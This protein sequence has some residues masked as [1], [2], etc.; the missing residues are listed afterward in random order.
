M[1]QSTKVIELGSCAFR[2]PKA[3]SHCRHLHGYRLVAKIWF[4]SNELDEN[5]WVMDFGALKNLKSQLEWTFDHSLIVSANDPLLDLFKQVAAADGAKIVILED[6]VG[7]EK[8]AKVVFEKADVFAREHTGGRVWVSKVEI[9]EHEKNSAIYS[10]EENRERPLV[11]IIDENVSTL[12]TPLQAEEIKL[13]PSSPSEPV[14][15][16]NHNPYAARVGN[17]VTKGWS[18]PFAGTSW[19][20]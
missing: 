8:F 18:N 6:G 20:A 4:N 1:Y 13:Q 19:G 2:Q 9:W 3:K 5:N 17:V 7:I 15:D 16:P 14:P 11:K 10:S 12:E